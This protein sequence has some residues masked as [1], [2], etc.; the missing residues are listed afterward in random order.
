MNV[1]LSSKNAIVKRIRDDEVD[2]L[3]I[4]ALTGILVVT[5]AVDFVFHLLK[6]SS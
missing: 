6:R 5:G 4:M 3:A 1:S 2:Y